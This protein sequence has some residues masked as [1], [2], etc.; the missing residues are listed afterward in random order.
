MDYILVEQVKSKIKGNI[1][2]WDWERLSDERRE[3]LLNKISALAIETS[4]KIILEKAAD[5]V[6]C[7][8]CCH[9]D[10]A[11]SVELYKA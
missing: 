9:D 4:A 7:C 10:V 6:T 11:N 5:C 1:L 3:T 2:G 8:P